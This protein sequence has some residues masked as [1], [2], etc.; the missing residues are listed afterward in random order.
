MKRIQAWRMTHPRYTDSALTGQGAMQYGGRFNSPGRALVYTSGSISLCMLEMLVQG[1]RA[2]RLSPYI[3][4]G[5]QFDASLVEWR[6]AESLPAGWDELPYTSASQETGDE[7][8]MLQ[9]SAV[10]AVPSV[11]VHQEWNFLLN[12]DHP[13]FRI[14][15]RTGTVFTPFDRRL[16][17]SPP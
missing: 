3:C 1:N 17:S 10:L 2:E 6:P 8:L 4:I 14:I 13:H 12:P 9:R 16:V 7:W 11:V 5:L 15:E